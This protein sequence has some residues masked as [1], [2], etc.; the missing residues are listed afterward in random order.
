MK[1]L[2]LDG[3]PLILM[4]VLPFNIDKCRVINYDNNNIIHYLMDN[5]L[6]LDDNSI[7]DLGI[8]FH[9]KLKF[10]QYINN[11]TTSAN[12]KICIIQNTFN[13]LTFIC[14]IKYI[15]LILEYIVITWSPHLR[16]HVIQIKSIQGRAIKIIPSIDF[17]FVFYN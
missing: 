2:K 7:K 5:K 8:T 12:S 13:I 1:T 9:N 11:I 17:E 16:R 6:L 10:D 4:I 3:I 15:R 14:Y